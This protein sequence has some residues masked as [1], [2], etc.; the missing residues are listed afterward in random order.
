MESNHLSVSSPPFVRMDYFQGELH[1]KPSTAAKAN[2]VLVPYS[3]LGIIRPRLTGHDAL[4]TRFFP[5]PIHY[6]YSPWFLLL[7]VCEY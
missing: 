1:A 7:L 4:V 2:K 5:P 6:L 3:T